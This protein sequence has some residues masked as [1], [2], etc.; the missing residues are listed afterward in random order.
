MGTSSKII[1]ECNPYD[2]LWSNGFNIFNPESE[3]PKKWKGENV[4]G[5]IL[6]SVREG[7]KEN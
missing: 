4:T 7:H 3:D 6:T 1:V 2:Q 5:S